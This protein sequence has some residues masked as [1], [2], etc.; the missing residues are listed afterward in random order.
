MRFGLIGYLLILPLILQG[1]EALS[2]QTSRAFVYQLRLSEAGDSLLQSEDR[3]LRPWLPEEQ[4][5]WQFRDSAQFATFFR[6]IHPNIPFPDFRREI[7]LALIR[8][9]PFI[10]DMQ[11]QSV[12]WHPKRIQLDIRYRL[13][14]LHPS[15]NGAVLNC[16]ILRIPASQYLQQLGVTNFSFRLQEDFFSEG[17]LPAPEPVGPESLL[18]PLAFTLEDLYPL[19]ELFEQQP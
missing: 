19:L 4:F 6:P 13:A 11:V 3:S 12:D 5:G 10:A 9:E 1:Q 16:L 18:F 17:N 14:A 2:F 7:V 8:Y 15:P